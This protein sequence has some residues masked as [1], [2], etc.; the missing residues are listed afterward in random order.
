VTQSNSIDPITTGPVPRTDVYFRIALIV[1]IGLAVWFAGREGLRFRRWVWDTTTPIRFKG[2]LDRGFE[3]G[4]VSASE[5]ML[6]QYEKMQVQKP[7][8]KNW[9]D[10]GPLRLEVMT[11]WAKWAAVHHPNVRRWSDDGSYELTA[12]LLRFTLGT[13]IAGAVAAF[14]LVRLWARRGSRRGQAGFF[15]GVLPG[16]FA[17]AVL[18]FNPATALDGHGWP[19]DDVWVIPFFLLA[20]VAASVGWWFAAGIVLGVGAMLKGQL[21]GAVPV[22]AIWAL[23]SGPVGNRSGGAAHRQGLVGI[24]HRT[25]DFVADL[26]SGATRL[27]GG[28]VVAVA[29]IASPWLLSSIPADRLA[30]ARVVQSQHGHEPWQSPP[31]SF[32]IARH[33]NV[34]VIVWVAG[35][36]VLTAGVPWVRKWKTNRPGWHGRVRAVVEHP[37]FWPAVGGLTAFVW[38]IWPWLPAMNRPQAWTGFVCAVAVAI[39]VLVV[40]PGRPLVK[41]VV[42]ATAAALLLCTSTFNASTA[43]WDCGVRFVGGANPA[44]F[45]N[46]QDK[47]DNVARLLTDD[48]FHWS[49]NN[50]D[51]PVTTLHRGQILHVWPRQD[52]VVGISESLRFVSEAGVLIAAI[53]LGVQARRRDARVLVALVTPWIWCY[54]FTPQVQER[55]LV[56]AAAV[57]CVCAGVSTGMTL[58]GMIL[59][60]I[61]TLTVLHVMLI[62]AGYTATGIFKRHLAVEFPSLFDK[63]GPNLRSLADHAFPEL[64]WAVILIALIYLYFAL[65]FRGSIR[66]LVVPWKRRET[67]APVAKAVEFGTVP[68]EAVSAGA[69]PVTAMSV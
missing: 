63:D 59:S 19:G 5:G 67:P 6:N 25:L 20:A 28:A 33:A 57:T 42:I 35:I 44:Q 27:V 52:R 65:A 58:L 66:G 68:A 30:A 46:E 36:A 37:W 1:L 18:W 16:L 47:P 9:L 24:A 48:D 13:E 29:V 62:S 54:C 53:G 34:G 69:D 15:Q 3:W 39:L 60:V 49:P 55:Y 14:L 22:F 40:R 26:F 12:P 4:R 64:A 38:T 17:A 45:V 56:F 50:P 8:D 21:L 51:E 43:W 61:A 41:P 7:A 2:G 10:Y 23:I 32:A 31:M 11:L